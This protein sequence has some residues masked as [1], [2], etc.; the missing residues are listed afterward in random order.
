[1]VAEEG[2]IG[3][4][5]QKLN[6]GPSALTRSIGDFEYQLKTQLFDRVPKGMRLTPQGER[7][8]AF[9]KQFLEQAE[10][11]ERIFKE[12]E[13]EIEGEIRILTTPYIGTD[14]LICHLREFLKRYPKLTLKIILSYEKINS[15]NE[16]DIAICS[17]IPHQPTLIQEPL[18]TLTVSLFASPAYLKEMGIPQKP[19]DLDHHHLI[20]YSEDYYLPHGNW[21]LNVGNNINIPPRK[22]YIQIYSLHG[23]INAA[24]QGLGIIEAPDL[25][26][27]LKSGL[28]RVLPDLQGP[29]VPYYFVFPES[30]KKSKKINYLFN[31]LSK[32]G[33]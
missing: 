26:V 14:W 10:S 4:A 16:N 1:M 7:L 5:A 8:H 3:K 25:S 32:I 20:V 19:Q 17:M 18:F 24:L 29:Q 9:A 2:T 6:V 33:K 21:I 11:F 13:D 22:P 31:Y 23:M 28:E 12:K 30:R 27:I 15:L